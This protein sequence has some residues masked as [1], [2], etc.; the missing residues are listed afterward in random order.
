MN[1]YHFTHPGTVLRIAAE[2]LKP[3]D[4][5]FMSGGLPV[6]WLTR[7]QSNVMTAADV[8]HM[9]RMEVGDLNRKDGDLIFGGK[10]RLTVR[11]EP[12][13]R[14]VKYRDFLRD[15]GAPLV[16]PACLTQTALTQWYVYL[17]VIPPRKIDIT[18]TVALIVE[19]L[20][21][22]IQTHPDADA[23]ERFAEQR[24]QIAT[25][26]PDRLASFDLRTTG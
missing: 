10:A 2:G 22:H 18:M 9:H 23:R 7:Q 15:G 13:K 21:H 24:A 4:D 12:Q 14:L 8:A 6:V 25:L 19:C 20:D 16:D 1:L 3:N 26:P 11:L 5:D 17:G